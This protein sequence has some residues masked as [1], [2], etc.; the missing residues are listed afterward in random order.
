MNQPPENILEAALEVLYLCACS[1]RNWTLSEEISRRQINDLWEAVHE[2]P[3]LLTRWRPDAEK[4]LLTY[5]EEYNER[6]ASP[7][8]LNRYI[9]VRDRAEHLQ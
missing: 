6:W 4:E 3:I 7:S 9:D 8:L 5:L 2:I 1:T